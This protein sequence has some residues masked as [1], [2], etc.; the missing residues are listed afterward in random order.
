MKMVVFIKKEI[1][2]QPM[3][4]SMNERK[5]V[6]REVGKRYQKA[7]KREKGRMLDEFT[8]LTGYTRC[9]A[10]YALRNLGRKV[11][12]KTKWGERIVLTGNMQRKV[13]RK[14]KERI[15]DQKVFMALR[16]IW[17]IEDY[18]CGKRLAPYMKE[19]VPV[20]EIWKELTIDKETREKLLKISAATIDRLLV[21]ER[22]KF[23]LKGRSRTKPG[24]L[25]KNQIP[26]RTFSDNCLKAIASKSMICQTG[27]KTNQVL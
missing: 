24:T 17:E 20:L 26:I 9:Y 18:I 6:T 1:R 25:L 4:L 14:K 7:R 2:R 5:A 21:P 22:K 8:K 13:K 12:L 3:G 15:Y 16:K 10:S 27:V 19:I 11:I 23:Q